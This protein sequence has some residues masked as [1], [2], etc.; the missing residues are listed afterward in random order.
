[1]RVVLSVWFVLK[2][3]DGDPPLEVGQCEAERS[4][5]RRRFLVLRYAE[6]GKHQIIADIR[7]AK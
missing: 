3:A 1:M 5:P 7:R 6:V 2:T 4:L